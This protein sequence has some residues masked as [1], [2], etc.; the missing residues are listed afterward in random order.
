MKFWI[1]SYLLFFILFLFYIFFYFLFFHISSIFL[2][3][4]FFY[5]FLF[6]C[7]Y[8]RVGEKRVIHNAGNYCQCTGQ[9]VFEN[10]RRYL[11]HSCSLVR[12]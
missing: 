11:V 8:K 7:T 4:Y 10:S 2:Y 6:P 5:F 3:S 9:T 1:F 12:W